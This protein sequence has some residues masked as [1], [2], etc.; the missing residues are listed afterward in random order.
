[1]AESR[2]RW[3]WWVFPAAVAVAGGLFALSTISDSTTKTSVADAH[4]AAGERPPET[5]LQCD[6]GEK[7]AHGIFDYVVTNDDPGPQETRD[8]LAGELRARSL[9]LHAT[10]DEFVPGHR[11]ANRA[12][13]VLVRDGRVVAV[14]K[15]NHEGRS[16]WV[17][18]GLN[19]CVSV[20]ADA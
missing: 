20:L 12:E 1:M 7:E 16:G 18:G 9:R 8:A 10:I 13:E 3:L 19:A 15:L 4:D 17:V 11:S 6:A 14:V 2:R 5:E